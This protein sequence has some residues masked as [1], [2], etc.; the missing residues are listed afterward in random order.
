MKC[1]P[2]LLFAVAVLV[3]SQ[4]QGGSLEGYYRYPAIHDDF[5]IFTSEGDLYRV[6]IE[7]GTARRLT[8][9]PDL[10]YRS[11]I[12]PDGETVAFS[13]HYEGPREVYTMPVEVGLPTRR[14]FTGEYEHVT[15]WTPDGK[16]IYTTRHFSTL[17]NWQLATV[18]IEADRVDRHLSQQ[19]RPLPDRPH[20]P[21]HVHALHFTAADEADQ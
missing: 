18:D 15:G 10:E 14:T 4:V 5:I 12:S 6:G 16:V 21:G 3:S 17:P 19:H 8:T 9:H 7:G 1:F 13:A 11:A 2:A 20:G